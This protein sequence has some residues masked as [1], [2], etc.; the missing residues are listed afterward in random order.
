[1]DNVVTVELILGRIWQLG[2]TLT[3]VGDRIRYRPA[4]TVPPDLLDDLRRHKSDIIKHLAA[5]PSAGAGSAEADSARQTGVEKAQSPAE[6]LLNWLLDRGS[7]F[8]IIPEDG[9]DFLVWFGPSSAVTHEIRTQVT[10]IK[11]EIIAL[12]R[13]GY[14]RSRRQWGEPTLADWTRQPNIGH[15]ATQ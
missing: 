4:S 3:L 9:R 10:R 5:K 13:A 7:T 6:D 12:L 8:R 1:M 11:P 15:D 14:P 2:V